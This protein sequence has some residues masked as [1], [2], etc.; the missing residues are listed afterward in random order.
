MRLGADT[1]AAEQR[2]NLL[3]ELIQQTARVPWDDR[4]ALHSGL[5]DLHEMT[6]R[7][8]LHEIGSGLADES[9]T[10]EIYRRMR[11][12]TQ[13]NDHDVPATSGCCSSLPSQPAGFT[14]PGSIAHCSLPA[15][16]ETCRKNGSF[17]A[18]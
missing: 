6:I 15:A 8:H 12:T 10:A 17:A 1:V 13:V 14:A 16:A 2:G 4:R 7:E 18:G 5:T 9:D 11:I 3:R